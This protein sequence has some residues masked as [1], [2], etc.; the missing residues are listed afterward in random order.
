VSI[1][2][3]AGLDPELFLIRDDG[4]LL[5]AIPYFL[6]T[7]DAQTPLKKGM[8]QH[9]NVAV[10]F[11][12][13][14]A[15][16]EKA[17]LGNIRTVLSQ[18]I[19]MVP[20]NAR[21]L[22][23]ASEIFPSSELQSDEANRF[24]CDVDFDAYDVAPNA[25]PPDAKTSNLRSCGGHIHIGH[26]AIADD[27]TNQIGLTKAMDVF[28]GIPSLLLD[29]DPTSFRRRKLYGKAGCH[30]PK[31][32]GIEYR[33]LGN[34]WVGT[35]VLAG[36]IYRLSASALSAYLD[37]HMEGINQSQVRK[38]INTND[39]ATARKIVDGVIKGLFP[40]LY[41]EIMVQSQQP[42]VDDVRVGWDL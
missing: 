38:V 31:E 42:L 15:K 11:G 29:K 28:V 23:R 20:K 30:R 34:F 7:K 8:V 1:K 26:P 27:F 5:S 3:T 32:Y 35:E 2:F 16:T 40:N 33:T 17:W 18:I 12:I 36:L 21:L 39:V 22:V 25:A 41:D 37:G 13:E 19:P 10:E 9:D 6:G 14:P 24:F 4:A